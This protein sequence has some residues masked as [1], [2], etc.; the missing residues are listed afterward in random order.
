ML[1]TILGTKGEMSY[2]FNQRGIRVP[3]TTINADPN[4]VVI[5]K[6]NKIQ[7]LFG[8][9][10]KVKKTENFYTQAIGFSPRAIREVKIKNQEEN[11]NQIKNGD[12]ITV[13]IFEPQD[14]V[15]VTGI[16]K[17][18]GFAGSVKRWGFHGGPKTHGQSDRHRAAG[19]IG[20]GTTPGRVFKG[21]KM[22]GH[23]GAD[24]LTIVGIE[25]VEV[26]ADANQLLVKGP[27]PGAKNGLLI[28]EKVGKV[29]S[30][31]PPPPPS[32]EKAEEKEE[33]EE[34]KA[35]E[36]KAEEK[37]ETKEE[38]KEQ[39]EEEKKDEQKGEGNANS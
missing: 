38:I 10:K 34:A 31:T 32:E 15:K 16:T 27:V 6:D 35:E 19:S 9:K 12:K 22:A 3:V 21:K 20:Q 14:E 33:R 1:N 13:A 23:M 8:Q 4:T 29:K 5:T 24:K 2:R 25:V 28:I 37:G 30:Y 26:I 39:N 7:L 18:K 11:E 17:G 36:A